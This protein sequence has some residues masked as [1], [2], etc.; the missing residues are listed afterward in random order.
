MD[1]CAKLF[2]SDDIRSITLFVAACATGFAVCQPSIAVV[3]VV[4]ILVATMGLVVWIVSSHVTADNVLRKND[5]LSTALFTSE[6]NSIEPVAS[7]VH[8][9][10]SSAIASLSVLSRP[11][12]RNAVRSVVVA[13][14]NVVKSYHAVLALPEANSRHMASACMDDLRDRSIV[15]LDALQ[16]LR[17]DTGSR[18][19]ASD[20]AFH[21]E[22][23]LRR[24]FV[25]FRQIA[26][27]KLKAPHI[28]G[29]PFP[30]DPEDDHRF[31]R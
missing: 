19:D 25:R 23:R 20:V 13:T 11:G 6:S 5:E 4:F 14:D 2:A 3:Q 31:L 21:A 8:P 17:M 16:G 24:L 12:H 30:C 18:G 7:L 10:I 22:L 27:N 9:E 26:C 28:Y 15:A 1:V 29:P